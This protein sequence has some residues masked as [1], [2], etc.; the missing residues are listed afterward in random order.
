MDEFLV[1]ERGFW[2]LVQNGCAGG[3]KEPDAAPIDVAVALHLQ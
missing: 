2:L 3:V 1:L